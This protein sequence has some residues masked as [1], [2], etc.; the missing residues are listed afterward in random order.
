MDLL[1][2]NLIQQKNDLSEFKKLAKIAEGYKKIIILG[3]GGSSLGGKTLCSL[4]FQEKVESNVWG[5]VVY[6]VVQVKIYI[7]Y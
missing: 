6:V 5:F 1:L 2:E 4:K 7:H 3:V